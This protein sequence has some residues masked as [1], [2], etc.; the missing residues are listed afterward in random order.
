MHGAKG[1]NFWL[2]LFDKDQNVTTVSANSSE[3]SNDYFLVSP[4][5][6]KANK[7]GYFKAIGVYPLAE[8]YYAKGDVIASGSWNTSGNP[9]S[10]YNDTVYIFVK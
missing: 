9:F 8:K 3:T 10:E 7:N 2:C 4:G 6:I 5:Y 1:I